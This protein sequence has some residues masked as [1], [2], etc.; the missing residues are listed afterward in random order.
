MEVV[1][2]NV[3]RLHDEYEVAEM[4]GVSVGTVRRWRLFGKG[5]KFLK[6]GVLVKYRISDVERWLQTRPSGGTQEVTE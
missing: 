5:P 1:Q 3:T 4:L 6:L 2:K